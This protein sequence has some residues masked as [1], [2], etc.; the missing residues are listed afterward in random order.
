MS[1]HNLA[2]LKFIKKYSLEET[3]IRA[4]SEKKIDFFSAFSN[5]Q[6]ETKTFMLSIQ[7]YK[8]EKFSPILQTRERA[9]IFLGTFS[10]NSKCS[11]MERQCP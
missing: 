4:T 3:W 9:G 1:T 6:I 11:K 8:V 7:I 5:L 2:T 10:L